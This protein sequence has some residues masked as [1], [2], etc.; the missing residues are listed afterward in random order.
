MSEHT[1]K[2]LNHQRQYIVLQTPATST[3]G[4]I[5]NAIEK[6]I[7]QQPIPV[8]EVRDHMTEKNVVG[9]L[10]A[11]ENTKRGNV[12]KNSTFNNTRRVYQEGG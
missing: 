9:S 11:K 1:R 4:N 5:N 8:I 7:S 2:S 6:R 10:A 12:S 3:R